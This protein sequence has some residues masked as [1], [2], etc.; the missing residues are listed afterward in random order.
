[1]E[2]NTL[3]K[4]VLAAFLLLGIA[5]FCFYGDD[6]ARDDGSV[7]Q[8]TI[9]FTNDVHGFVERKVGKRWGY[10]ALAS[11]VKN[12]KREDPEML[13]IDAGDTFSGGGALAEFTT[14][15][16]IVDIMD[17]IGYDIMTVGNHDF[18]YS[19][20]RLQQLIDTA[21]F[22]I[23]NANVLKDG[24]PVFTP[25]VTRQVKGVKISFIGL[26]TEKANN[27]VNSTD[28]E[29]LF[30]ERPE[31][32]LAQY[33]PI[34]RPNSDI[35]VVVGHLGSDRAAVAA[36]K[37]VDL[38]IDG[39]DHLRLT[40][41]YIN[42]VKIVSSGEYLE[43]FG[44]VKIFR[45]NGALLN[46][47]EYDAANKTDTLYEPTSNIK[48]D[49][50]VKKIIDRS[51]ERYR[52]TL[53]RRIASLPIALD[54]SLVGNRT[55]STMMTNFATDVMRKK[56]GADVAL[57]NGGSLR[58]GLRSGNVLYRDLLE[59]FPFTNRIMLTRMTGAEIKAAVNY[60][61]R[62]YPGEFGGFLQISG[63]KVYVN[64]AGKVD[65]IVT[66][67][68]VPLADKSVYKVAAT[69]FLMNGGD[70]PKV[71]ASKDT[72]QGFGSLFSA[73]VAGLASLNR[74]DENS[75]K[76]ERIIFTKK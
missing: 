56:S 59:V 22:A 46:N 9:G 73:M 66:N 8:I 67:A 10:A 68:G 14:G 21:D 18:N 49:A 4:V 7:T 27:Q 62:L 71:F 19:Y 28:R 23:I 48:E 35:V 2:K 36:V 13:L 43:R 16:L 50:A 38:I 41:K 61:L 34:I 60:G 44:V 40:N 51:F 20:K 70:G 53:N 57:L 15:K 74:E 29:N 64:A 58:G 69:D 65:R 3:K 39:H 6:G 45:Q 75:L 63:A 25:Y 17:E 5:F 31:K 76:Q 12:L 32:V 26:L 47:A 30:V 72:I 37:G 33:M 52:P 42:G 24:K 11:W 54:G 55:R 1:M